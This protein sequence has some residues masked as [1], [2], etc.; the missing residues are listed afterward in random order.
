[1]HHPMHIMS[2]A[3]RGFSMCSS[4][5][6]EHIEVVNLLRRGIWSL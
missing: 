6:S 1:M 2:F 3:T 4:R 5:G